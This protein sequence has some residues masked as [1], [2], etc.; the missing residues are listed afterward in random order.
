MKTVHFCGGMPRSGSTVLMNILQQNPNIFTTGTCALS[1]LIQ[2]HVLVKSRFREQFQAMDVKQAD[3]ALYGFVM[4]G[5][6]G[7]FSELTTKPLIISKNRNW[8]GIFH[9]FK[10]S[11]YIV[12][13]RDIRDI[14]E[15][16]EKINFNSLALH[17]VDNQSY[18]IVYGMSE[19]EKLNYYLKSKNSVSASLYTEIPRMMEWF[20]K[21]PSRVIFIRYEDFTKNPIYMLEKLYK[22]LTEEYYEHD[23]DNIPSSTLYEHDNAYFCERTSHK[24][25]SQFQYYKE[26]SRS[27]S[28]KFHNNIVKNLNW[29]YEAFYPDELKYT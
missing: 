3:K 13:L 10:Q 4:G 2:Q 14:I 15:S 24:T 26:P 7:W 25:N 5:I 8:S 23:L 20:H 12:M 21:D 9:M 18:N 1:D 19:N 16:F 6:N 17:T 22:F 27:L 29:Y 11:K 28:M